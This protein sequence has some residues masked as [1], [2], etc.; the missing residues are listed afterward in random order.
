MEAGQSQRIWEELYKVLDASDVVVQ[1]I[2][3]RDP[4]GTRSHHVEE[5][6]KK[7]APH[8][9]F[10]LLLNKVDLIPTWLTAKW[11][12][13]LQREYPTL[14]FHASLNNPFGKGSLINLLR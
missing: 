6:L 5:H 9:H 3:A 11:V 13:S 2:D 14:A 4:M 12:K 8:K 1:V 10:V 7:N